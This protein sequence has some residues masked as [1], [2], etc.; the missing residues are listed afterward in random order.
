MA[1]D[2]GIGMVVSLLDR[3]MVFWIWRD[4]SLAFRERMHPRLIQLIAETM[5][6][7]STLQPFLPEELTSVG[8]L[9]LRGMG[10]A[11]A[12]SKMCTSLFLFLYQG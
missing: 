11:W 7:N 2:L 12:K 1:G 4:S 9:R 3:R 5:K 8:T 6:A 10:I